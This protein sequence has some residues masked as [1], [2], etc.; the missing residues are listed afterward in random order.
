MATII[1]R[2]GDNLQTAINN[3]VA[4]DVIEVEAN[5]TFLGPFTLPNKAGS[6]M[7]TIRSSAIAQLPSNTRVAPAQAV[8]MPKMVSRGFNEPAVAANPGAHHFTF[9]GIEF[10]P[11]N[12]TVFISDIVRLGEGQGEQTL[13]AQAPH[14]IVFDRCYIHGHPTQDNQRG[15]SAN[16]GELTVSNCYI[17][18][19]HGIGFD[20][21]AICGWNGPGPFHIINNYLEGAGEN[22][23]FGGAD[24]AI[25]ELMPTNLEFRRNYCFK[26]LTWRVGHPSYAGKHWTVKNLFEL[27]ALSGA[28]IDGNVFEN[29]WTDGQD[30]SG[31][32]FTVRNQECGAPWSIVENVTFTNN[33]VKNVT[34][35]AINFL[36]EDNEVTAAFGKCVPASTSGRGTD[37]LV[38]NNVFHTV[39]GAFL[40]L[41]GFYNITISR[42][43]HLQ[44]GNT[45]TLYGQ[46]S[47]G[48]SYIDNVTRE[49]EFGI[50]GEGGLIGTAALEAWTPGYTF[51]GN[52]L[53][54]PYATNPV[55]NDYPAE[56]TITSDFRVPDWPGKGCDIDALLAAQTGAAPT[57]PAPT[58]STVSPTSGSTLGGTV[59]SIAGTG[60]L[61]GATV[62]VGGTAAT[63]VVVNTSTSITCT[64][65]AHVA[66]LVSVVVT[67]PDI[68]SATKSN[69]F[70]YVAPPPPPPTLSVIQ[71]LSGPT[72]GGT[73]FTLTGTNFV[74]GAT[75]TFDGTSATG[76]SVSNSTTIVGLTPP[77]AA[78]GVAVVVTNPSGQTATLPSGYLYVDPLPPPPPPPPARTLTIASSTPGSG[79]AITVTPQDINGLSNGTTGFSRTYNDQTVVSVLAPALTG[80]N[81]FVKWQRDG[82]DWSTSQ[83]TNVLMN[84]NYTLTAVYQAPAPP[85]PPAPTYR[86]TFTSS[87]PSTG[88]PISVSPIDNNQ[89]GNGIT[90]FSRTYNEGAAVTMIAPASAS[91]NVFRRWLKDGNVVTSNQTFTTTLTADVEVQ[92]V[93]EVVA[94]EPDPTPPPVAP[95]PTISSISPSKG[96]ISGGLNVTITGSNFE[97]GATIT[98]G[99]TAA[100]GVVVVSSTTIRCIVPSRATAGKV[101]VKVTNPDGKSATKIGGFQYSKGGPRNSRI[102]P[103]GGLIIL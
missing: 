45:M 51:T 99:G 74:A 59:M 70:T 78:G 19:I 38:N 32:L 23:L 2:A 46:D 26:P 42:N 30:G 52:V 1:V 25:A 66:G 54:H 29:N 39:G 97:T 27:K 65:P 14:D 15:I 85:P 82:I 94:P 76:V 20:T 41:N 8:L 92:A 96:S 47:L 16:T 69:S 98:F 17:S 88:V 33:T 35:A 87:S 13:V 50:F 63:N 64:T 5:A 67:N 83:S 9:Q 84:S 53:A 90:V 102:S 31:I 91:G 81:T 103:N 37:V 24:S 4:G 7:I 44:N 49:Q 95:A 89:Q 100:T 21:Q 101:D 72:T 28:V 34:G 11:V 80:A 48:F 75:V 12:A 93:Y 6:S 3:A 68:Q 18:E 79:V 73:A 58:I 22:V 77:H 56:V 40:L 71:P 36:G 10:A 60:F 55:G 43:T 61:S 57:H 62:T 86:L